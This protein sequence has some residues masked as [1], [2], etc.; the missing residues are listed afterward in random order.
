METQRKT[1]SSVREYPT[2]ELEWL[3]LNTTK[4]VRP[5]TTAPRV[6]AAQYAYLRPHAPG[7]LRWLVSSNLLVEF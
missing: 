3:Q 4:H 5:F 1:Q 6:L 7:V 2:H